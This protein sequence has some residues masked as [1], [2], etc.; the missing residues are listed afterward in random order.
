V[1]AQYS[2]NLIL[3]IF[4]QMQESIQG[5]VCT[6]VGV[7]KENCVKLS[8]SLVTMRENLWCLTQVFVLKALKVLSG[9]Q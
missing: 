6:N 4:F 5:C 2:W 9:S 7:G 3:V 1:Y 8:I